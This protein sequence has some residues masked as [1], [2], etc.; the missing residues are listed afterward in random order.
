MKIDFGDD[1]FFC[2]SPESSV[3]DYKSEPIK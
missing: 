2:L 3:N 1:R